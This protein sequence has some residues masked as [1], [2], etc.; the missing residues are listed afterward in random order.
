MFNCCFKPGVCQK[1]ARER[2]RES[3]RRWTFGRKNV[4]AFDTYIY[5][6]NYNHIIYLISYISI[7][8]SLIC[9]CLCTCVLVLVLVP[10]GTQALPHTLLKVKPPRVPSKPALR[11]GISGLGISVPK[12]DPSHVA[13]LPWPW[14]HR[15]RREIWIVHPM[16][17]N[18][19]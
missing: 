5:I 19:S 9:V 17:W 6:Y 10:L 8:L 11:L 1:V 13:K 12:G 2:E 14:W 4:L 18:I 7:S 15:R 16:G 3:E